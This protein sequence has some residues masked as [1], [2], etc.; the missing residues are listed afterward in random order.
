MHV[1]VDGPFASMPRNVPP[2]G[3]LGIRTHTGPTTL[4]FVARMRDAWGSTGMKVSPR[5]DFVREIVLRTF[6]EF[7]KEPVEPYA[8]VEMILIQEGKYRGR[9]YRS[10]RLMAMW[11]AEIGLVQVYRD[12]G[13]MLRTINL[14]EE[15]E[16]PRKV[17]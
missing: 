16:A 5:A 6:V 8:M 11:L 13:E 9:S 14:F 3:R 17:A 4:F 7:S 12:D 1:K 15:Q 10:N 2:V